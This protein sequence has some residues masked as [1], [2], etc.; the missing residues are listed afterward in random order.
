MSLVRIAGYQGPDSILTASLQAFIDE[1]KSAFEPGALSCE[2][3]VPAQ[4]ETA[5]SLFASV[6]C[7]ERQVCYV[8]SGYLAAKVPE[9]AVL[10][11]PFSVQDRAAALQRLDGSAGQLLSAAVEARTSYKVL[12]FWDNGFRH[13][14]NA[15]RPIH[16]VTDCAGLKIRTLDSA[17]YR[18]ALSALG[19]SP[20][21]IDVKNLVRA[22]ESRQVDAQ[23]NPLTNFYH[24][25]LYQHHPYVSLTSHFFGVL[26]FV[27]NRD[28]FAALETAQQKAIADAAS[29]ATRLQRQKARAEDDELIIILK[30]KGIEVAAERDLDLASMK[31]ATR[32]IVERESLALPSAIVQAYIQ[33]RAA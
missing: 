30:R 17:L 4:G 1:I 22:V 2:A 11:L 6:E 7:G 18:E 31:R 15:V 26:L 21:S 3:N 5:A 28:W 24:F 27:C 20:L 19:F 29:H 16:T 32:F 33:E 25:G 12:G 10:D 8:A 23:E 14:S 9:L 13:L